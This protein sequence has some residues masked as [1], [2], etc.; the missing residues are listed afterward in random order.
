M[1]HNLTE[2]EKAQEE[3]RI[4][5]QRLERLQKNHPVGSKGFTKAGVRKMIARLH[6]EL[7]LFEGSEEARQPV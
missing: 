1:I 4:L 3:M 5:E 2:Y 7:A 6:E